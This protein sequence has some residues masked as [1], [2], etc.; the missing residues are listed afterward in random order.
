MLITNLTLPKDFCFVCDKEA[1]SGVQKISRKVAKDIE[2]IFDFYPEFAYASDAKSPV[3]SSAQYSVVFGTIG[4]SAILDDLEKSGVLNFDNIRGKWEVYGFYVLDD[5]IVIAGSDKRGTIYG[6]FHISDLLGVSPFVDFSEM[7]PSKRDSFEFTSD[8]TMVSKEPSVKYRGFFINDE[9]PAFG[10]WAVTHFGGPNAE[11]YEHVFEMLLRLKGNYLWPAMWSAVFSWDGPDLL[12]AKHADE[13]GIVMGTSHHE[14]CGRAGEEHRVHRATDQKYGT[15]WNFSHNREGITNFWRDGLKRN[16]PY[17]NIWTVGM[18]GEADS[19]ILGHEAT[20]QDNI[21]LLKDVLQTQYQLMK[22]ELDPDLSKIRRQLVMFSEV[23]KFYFGNETTKGLKDTDLLDGVSIMMTDDNYGMIRALPDDEMRHR[24]GPLGLYYHYDFHGPTHCYEWCNE[25]YL[26]RS[27]EQLTMAYDYGI[28]DVWI[29]NVGD[30]GLLEMPLNYFMDFAYDY[31]KWG[32]SNPNSTRAWTDQ[33][34]EKQFGS[35]LLAKDMKVLKELVQ[36]YTSLAGKCRNEALKVNTYH[37]TNFLEADRMMAKAEEIIKTADYI[38]WAM[39]ERA[40]SAYWELVYY[41]AVGTA[42]VCRIWLTSA[43]NHLYAKQN[44]VEA[45]IYADKVRELV[46]FDQALTDEYHSVA[47]GKFYGFGL[48]EH[49]GFDHWNDEDDKKPMMVSVFPS[50]KPRLVVNPKNTEDYLVGT[51]YSPKD[52][53]I[54]TFT[55]LD[56][57]QCQIDLAPSCKESIDYTV[58]TD[59]PWLSLSHTKG[60]ASVTHDTLTVF[61]DRSK[62]PEAAQDSQ[63]LAEGIVKVD[64]SFSHMKLHFVAKACTKESFKS[65]TFIEGQDVISIEAGHISRKHDGSSLKFTELTDYGRTRSAIKVLPTLHDNLKATDNDTPYVEYDFVADSEG[66]YDLDFYFSPTNPPLIDN[67]MPYAYAVNGEAPV[68]KNIVALDTFVTYFSK[69][70][71]EGAD[72]N[73]RIR[74]VKINVKKGLNTLRFYALG[75]T[76]VLEKLV[77]HNAE[78]AL[79]RTYLGAPESYFVE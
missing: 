60:T 39:P 31:D 64:T 16:A 24:N 68:E 69:E 40:K 11:C 44:R 22:E 49:M 3:F 57:T 47:G 62:M 28:R 72:N 52:M 50:K 27:W 54:N 12:N 15:E 29:V 38:K 10:N 51:D 77:L 19:A 1:Y 42:N 78:K 4:N 65:L 6:L 53:V 41:S 58:S 59:C 18:R 23:D 46:E 48:S 55:K 8:M 7:L 2:R 25:N 33:W 76:V 26:P 17:E 75:P 74:S 73:I 13:Y 36:D 14:P 67:V 30:M 9:W 71:E 21:D 79:P 43:K 45:N 32:S 5:K 61:I 20:L 34:L 56:E 70:W 63:G 35:Y 37:V 66:I